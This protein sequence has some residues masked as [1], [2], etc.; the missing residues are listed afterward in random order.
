MVGDDIDGLRVP[1]VDKPP[2]L[3]VDRL[4]GLLGVVLLFA[5]LATEEN[6]LFLVAKRDGAKPL[7]HTVFLDH[8]A[9]DVGRLLDV[10]FGASRDFAEH[11]LLG[12]VPAKSR[13]NAR[14]ELALGHVVA[15]FWR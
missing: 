4:S 13:S 7:A 5:Y 9:G 14:F 3:F 12:R 8:L 2:D 1:F 10:V 15:I 11:H 6:E